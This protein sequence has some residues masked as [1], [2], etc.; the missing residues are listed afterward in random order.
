MV[1]EKALQMF[2]QFSRTP[3][4]W[5]SGNEM[6]FGETDP[7]HCFPPVEKAML[8]ADV[9]AAFTVSPEH[10]AFAFLRME[11]S[12]I[13]VGPAPA[14]EID[15]AAV[16]SMMD[17]IGRPPQNP[18]ALIASFHSIPYRDVMRFQA[19][20]NYLFFTLTDREI[21]EWT[22]VP[23]PSPVRTSEAW[24]M[25]KAPAV[26]YDDY[27]SH[28]LFFSQRIMDAIQHGKVTEL[29]KGFGEMNKLFGGQITAPVTTEAM[30]D[31]FV[32]ALA[33]ASDASMV[34]GLSPA[35]AEQLE[36]HYL[37]ALHRSKNHRDI[38]RLL[39]LMMIDFAAR[40]AQTQM[41]QTEDILTQRALQNIERHLHEKITP[42]LIAEQ[43]YVSVGHLCNTFKKHTGRTL[44]DYINERK[45]IEA[46]Y[47]LAQPKASITGTAVA[48]GFSSVNYFS[49]VFKK[50][51]GKTPTEYFIQHHMTI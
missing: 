12:Y 13:F 17:Y 15:E 44:S 21:S 40:T 36:A 16:R 35:V 37:V 2:Y 27:S 30:H 19:M 32:L 43:L 5:V 25:Q 3:L 41:I 10:I 18:A 14:V 20:L 48:L 50:Y 8:D 39:K 22:Y 49:T 4:K 31:R 11:Q 51:V 23:Y 45:T 29:E 33:K 6:E 46:K 34:G 26:E 9:P 42:T 24:P 7:G 28:R 1:I 47:L 38:V